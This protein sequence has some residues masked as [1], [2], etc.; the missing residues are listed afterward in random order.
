MALRLTSLPEAEHELAEIRATL[1]AARSLRI[2]PAT[3]HKRIAAWN[4]LMLCGACRWRTRV[5]QTHD[6]RDAAER[7]ATFLD[8]RDWLPIDRVARTWM[9]GVR[10]TPGFLED[11]AAVAAGLLALYQATGNLAH[12]DAARTLARA[13]VRDFHDA[14]AQQFLRYGARSRSADHAARAT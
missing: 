2:P 10:K 13:M 3:D 14:D 8:A 6:L 11:Q 12:L 7:L 9:D 1:L 5:R 4:G